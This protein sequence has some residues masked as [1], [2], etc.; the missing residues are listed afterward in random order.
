MEHSDDDERTVAD[1]VD[2]LHRKL[3]SSIQPPIRWREE[4]VIYG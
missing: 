4:R 3:R 2:D 1:R